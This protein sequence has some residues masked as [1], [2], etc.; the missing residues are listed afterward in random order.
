MRRSRADGLTGSRNL[1]RLF[2]CNAAMLIERDGQPVAIASEPSHAR[3]TPADFGA[4]A[5]VFG[6]ARSSVADR[7]ASV[8]PTGCSFR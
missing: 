4:A 8:L 6:K 1:A 2:D 3:L 5:I 7:H